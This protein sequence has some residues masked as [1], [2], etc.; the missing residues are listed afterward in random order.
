MLKIIVSHPEF[1]KLSTFIRIY[2]IQSH[3]NDIPALSNPFEGTCSS[4]MQRIRVTRQYYL[5]IQGRKGKTGVEGQNRDLT[6]KGTL[7]IYHQEY[8]RE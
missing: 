2:Y 7:V 8:L 3:W 1:H 6:T 4:I 5:L